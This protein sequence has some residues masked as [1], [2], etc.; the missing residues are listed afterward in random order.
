MCTLAMLLWAIFHPPGERVFLVPSSAMAPTLVLGDRAVMVRY[1]AGAAP[2]R[3]DV[4]AFTTPSDPFSVQVFRVVGLPGDR[5]RMAE[6][7]VVLNGVP[8]ARMADG[9]VTI[10]FGFET[11]EGDAWRET[12]PEGRSYRVADTEPEGF[13]DDTAE[14]AVP[15]GHYFVLGDNRDNAA[16]SRIEDGVGLVPAALVLGRM[17]R[18][19]A[20]CSDAGLFLAA[21][22]GL[23]VGP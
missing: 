14:T 17:D 15:T 10:D 3:G 4:I 7:A 1:A 22:T 12:L 19:L 11:I 18:V 16:D 5:V 9:P 23:A 8:L 13:L 6:G 2:A 21:R 20:S